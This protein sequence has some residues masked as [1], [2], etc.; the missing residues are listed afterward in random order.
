MTAELVRASSLYRFF[1]TGDEEVFALRGVDLVV[2]GGE[3]VAITGPS[4]SGKSTI[5]ACLAGLDEPDGGYVEVTG[6]RMTRRS[7]SVKARLRA[8][9]MGIVLQSGNLLSHLTVVENIRL[10]QHL[11]KVADKSAIHAL[12]HSVGLSHRATALPATLS[13]G[14]AARAAL[15]VALAAGPSILLCDEPTGEIDATTEASVLAVLKAQQD[16]G[17]A[18]IVATHSAPLAA[19]ADRILHLNAGRVQ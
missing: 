9:R 7:E 6:Q 3:F 4:G 10:Q 18:V 5:L 15:A 8:Q 14:E 11:A 12:L 1:H 16:K 13:G 19:R 17:T 2:T